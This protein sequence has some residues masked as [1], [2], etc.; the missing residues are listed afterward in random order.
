MF[1]FKLNW[2]HKFK[3]INFYWNRKYAIC[4]GC[5]ES[6]FCFPIMIGSSDTPDIIKVDRRHTQRISYT[7]KTSSN[8]PLPEIVPCLKIGFTWA[9]TTVE[10]ILLR[11]DSWNNICC[12]RSHHACACKSEVFFCFKTSFFRSLNEKNC[13]GIK[14]VPSN[15]FDK[16]KFH[17]SYSYDRFLNL[18]VYFWLSTVMMMA[19]ISFA[20]LIFK[21]SA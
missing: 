15:I 13:F 4:S 3:W 14:V 21:V 17:S 16:S 10:A 5:R 19:S 18:T 7:V 6:K 12:T 20:Y 8:K 9:Y 11:K 2:F 1:I